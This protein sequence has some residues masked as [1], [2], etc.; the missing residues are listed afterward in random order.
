MAFILGMPIDCLFLIFK[1]QR[2]ETLRLFQQLKGLTLERKHR[3][4]W[5]SQWTS[6]LI[7]M[8]AAIM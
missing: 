2:V 1:T 3:E 5:E 4:T 8:L 6:P 7:H